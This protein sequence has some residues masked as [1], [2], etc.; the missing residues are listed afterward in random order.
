MTDLVAYQGG[1]GLGQLAGLGL[2]DQEPATATDP[3]RD[4]MDED[5]FRSAVRTLIENARHLMEEEIEPKT[6]LAW[7]YYNGTVRQD[8]MGLVG[9]D[10]ETDALV[11]EGSSAV[12]TE[13]RDQVQMLIP[14]IYRVLASHEEAVEFTPQG[15]ED[16]EYV[17]QANDYIRHLFWDKNDGE[18]LIK[19][20][21][22]EWCVKFC[23][24][25]IWR[26]NSYRERVSEHHEL[27]ESQLQ[28]LM[29]TENLEI[30]DIQEEPRR[31]GM[32][33]Q[34]PDGSVMY[35]EQPMNFY[36][37]R[38]R[39]FEPYGRTKVALIPQDELIVDLEAQSLDEATVLGVDCERRAGDLIAMGLDAE[40][41]K[42]HAGKGLRR[43]TDTSDV[44]RARS[45]SRMSLSRVHRDVKD[46]SLHWC[47]VVDARVLVDRDGDGM[48]EPWRVIALGD[49]LEIA[50]AEEDPG[51]DTIVI[52]SPFP[53][54]HTLIGEGIVEANIDLQE[55]ETSILRRALDNYARTINPRPAVSGAV[56]DTWDDLLSWFGGP[57]NLGSQG[58]ISWL[59][60]PFHGHDAM[61]LLGFFAERRTLRTG[62]SPAAMGLD[63]SALKGQTTEGAAGILAGP[64]SRVE[65]LAREFAR[66]QRK[67]F[68][69]LLQITVR[70]QDR[71]DVVRLRNEFVAVD[72]SRWNPDLDVNVNV[73]LGMGSRIERIAVSNMITQKQEMLAAVKSPLFD[74]KKYHQGLSDMVVALGRKDPERYFLDPES[75]EFQENQQKAQQEQQQA[76][77]QQ[78]QMMA[79]LEKAKAQA[80]AEAEFSWSR[81]RR[82]PRASWR[83]CGL[84]SSRRRSRWSW[85]R[86][87]SCGRR[88]SNSRR[89][90]TPG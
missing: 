62:I 71:A 27:D 14:E 57:I 67:I 46:E 24:Y 44:R 78:A 75:P 40:L 16:Q 60:V 83:S 81:S 82:R 3:D 5:E 31:I 89:R 13:C 41:V 39:Y 76:M 20:G 74:V 45:A 30:E 10:P 33:Q 84:S 38:C 52:G 35:V 56:E 86:K 21:L 42:Q 34:M 87:A 90:S 54:P 63:P 77:Q 29:D 43:A 73:G 15:P 28:A 1:D 36:T 37:V 6:E 23:A 12:L 11:F 55:Q 19:D 18:Q 80:K 26:E 53:R 17:D 61:A 72:P 4:P 7:D 65:G 79:E 25:R 64:Q 58:S 85:A 69:A 2:P 51:S 47:R 59:D 22:L 66:M 68:K 32:P 50:W 49:P 9:K 70:F 48:A 8:P 88:S